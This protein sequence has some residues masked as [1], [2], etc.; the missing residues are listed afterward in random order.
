MIGRLGGDEFIVLMRDVPG[1]HL[2]SR[3]V[4]QVNATLRAA[5]RDG[6]SASCSMGIALYPKDGTTFSQLYRGADDAL[7]QAKSAGKDDFFFYSSHD[8]PA[9]QAKGDPEEETVQDTGNLRPVLL[10]RSEDEWRYR[11]IRRAPGPS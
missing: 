4:Q 6:F 7:Y 8:V 10:V 1:D 5:A 11:S 9:E 3:R 2:V